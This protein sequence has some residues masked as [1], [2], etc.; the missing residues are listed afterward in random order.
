MDKRPLVHFWTSGTVNHEPPLPG[1]GG[2]RAKKVCATCQPSVCENNSLVRTTVGVVSALFGTMSYLPLINIPPLSGQHRVLFPSSF[3]TLL[4]FSRGGGVTEIWPPAWDCCKKSPFL[5]GGSAPGPLSHRLVACLGRRGFPLSLVCR[6]AV[7]AGLL[8]G[9]A[10]PSQSAE[11]DDPLATPRRRTIAFDDGNAD[12]FS[13]D[14]TKRSVSFHLS[15]TKAGGIGFLTTSGFGPSIQL[16]PA[17]PSNV[18]RH[19]PFKSPVE[20]DPGRQN[21]SLFKQ[22]LSQ[23]YTRAK[24]QLGVLVD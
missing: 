22:G 6:L 21:R 20:L 4:L 3:G 19:P 17:S 18:L 13:D 1:R 15:P 9:M 10:S 16:E 11:I 24:A 23:L 14:E 8:S 2:Q 7:A 12:I 5:V